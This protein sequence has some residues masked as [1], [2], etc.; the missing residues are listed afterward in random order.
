MKLES[1]RPVTQPLPTNKIVEV[2]NL[3]RSGGIS[4]ENYKKFWQIKANNDWL[5]TK[6][7]AELH[8]RDAY[9]ELKQKYEEAPM[10]EQEDIGT[11]IKM[12]EDTISS[13]SYPFLALKINF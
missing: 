7:I 1:L 9:L 2:R 8:N 4:D 12:F 10:S 13:Y 5:E 6:W 11:V 3:R